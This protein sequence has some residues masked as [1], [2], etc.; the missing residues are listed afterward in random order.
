MIVVAVI[1][2][3]LTRSSLQQNL[4]KDTKL[5]HVSKNGV[6]QQECLGSTD[7]QQK[8]RSCQSLEF[9]AAHISKENENVIIIVETDMNVSGMV[10]FQRQNSVSI[11]SGDNG[12][13]VTVFCN[14]YL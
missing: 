3:S 11:L 12:T 13:S 8:H 5:I 7:G 2:L 14:C 10:N 1:L 4:V 9:V 6:N